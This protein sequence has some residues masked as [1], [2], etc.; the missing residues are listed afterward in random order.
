MARQLGGVGPNTMAN[1]PVS[2]TNVAKPGNLNAQ[3]E[4]NPEQI[5]K[6]KQEEERKR[7]EARSKAATQYLTK[8]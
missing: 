4:L 7:I 5:R 6:Q 3:S 8:K 1:A 2:R